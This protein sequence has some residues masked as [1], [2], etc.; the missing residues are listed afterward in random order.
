MSQTKGQVGN[1]DKIH[2]NR[3]ALRKSTFVFGDK[4]ELSAIV[5]NQPEKAENLQF[6]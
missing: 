5:P 4:L 6:F 2:S 3:G 1:I